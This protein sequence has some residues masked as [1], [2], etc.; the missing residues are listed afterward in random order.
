[1][2]NNIFIEKASFIRSEF[3]SEGLI[4][5]EIKSEGMS[6]VTMF[7]RGDIESPL[8]ILMSVWYDFRDPEWSIELRLGSGCPEKAN[9]HV[10]FDIS[11]VSLS[12]LGI[13]DKPSSYLSRSINDN[14]LRSLFS[15]AIEYC[16]KFIR[17]DNKEAL[18]VR[19]RRNSERV[20]DPLW[21]NTKNKANSDMLFE[22]NEKLKSIIRK[23]L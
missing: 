23:Y 14:E 6:E 1:M 13:L 19:H 18:M 22:R 17:G 16:I 10:E 4:T 20:V 2:E 8:Y 12:E 11:S 7:R 15:T 5:H 9:D 3:E 21:I